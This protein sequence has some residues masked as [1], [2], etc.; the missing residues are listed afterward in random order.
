[1]V[2]CKKGT[3]TIKAK[4]SRCIFDILYQNSL[5]KILWYLN[6]TPTEMFARNKSSATA[7]LITSKC[8][9]RNSLW[10][11]TKAISVMRSHSS[12]KYLKLSQQALVLTWAACMLSVPH[13]PAPLW[14]ELELLFNTLAGHPHYMRLSKTGPSNAGHGNQEHSGNYPR[15]LQG[16]H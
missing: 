11:T 1:M 14:E 5:H 8:C 3:L 2:T 4:Y 9:K 12:T 10:A 15:C 13:H 6:K 16:N 7:G